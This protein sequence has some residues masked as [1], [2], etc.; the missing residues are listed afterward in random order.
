VLIHGRGLAAATSV[1]FGGIPATSFTASDTWISADAP[2][3]AAGA[4]D[5][6]VTTPNGSSATGTAAS[7]GYGRPRVFGGPWA[8]NTAGQRIYLGGEGFTGATS[9]TFDGVPGTSLTVQDDQS[10]TVDAPAHAAGWVSV[11]VSGPNGTSAN[12]YTVPYVPIA[13]IGASPVAGPPGGGTTVSIFGVGFTG[14]TSVTFGGVPGTGLVVGDDSQLIVVTP[15]HAIGTVP[16]IVTS[17]A[18]NAGAPPY[19]YVSGPTVTSI[20]PA[21]GPTTGGTAVTI[22]GTGFTGATGVTFGGGAGTG[23]TVIS[24]TQVQ[25][26]A[27]AHAAGAVDVIVTTTGGASATGPAAQFTYTQAAPVV[28][29][30]WPRGGPLAGGTTVTVYGW[31]FSSATGVTFGGV[32]ATGMV[33]VDD[34]TLTVVSPLH[35]VGT[36]DVVVTTSAG[37]NSAVS[38]AS[39]FSYGIPWVTAAS[40]SQGPWLGGTSVSL[41]GGGFTG[42]S[43]VAFDGVLSGFSVVNDNQI[44]A[45]TPFHQTGTTVVTVTGP[46]GVSGQAAEY[47]FTG[48]A[49]VQPPFQQVTIGVPATF[50]FTLGAGTTCQSDIDPAATDADVDCTV[51]DVDI[52][53]TAVVQAFAVT[54]APLAAGGTVVT[55]T[56][57]SNTHGSGSLA[58]RGPLQVPGINTVDFWQ[59][60]MWAAI[61][62][63]L[64]HVASEPAGQ[65]VTGGGAAGQ[66]GIANNG[67]AVVTR[68]R[69]SRHTACTVA[70]GTGIQGNA[71]FVPA[72][73]P[74]TNVGQVVLTTGG[75]YDGPQPVGPQA[76]TFSDAQIFIGD[77]SNGLLGA[78]CISW[79][80]M[81]AGQQSMSV[82]YTGY[83]SATHSV[84]WDSD[85]DGNGLGLPSQ[86]LVTEWSVLE[87]VRMPTTSSPADPVNG[88]SPTVALPLVLNPG[89]GLYELNLPGA[90]RAFD[91]VAIGSHLNAASARF[92]SWLAGSGWTVA[93]GPGSCGELWGP[94]TSGT[95]SLTPQGIAGNPLHAVFKAGAALGNN[96]T[97][98]STAAIVLDASHR[99]VHRFGTCPCHANRAAGVGPRGRFRD[100]ASRHRCDAVR[101]PLQHRGYRRGRREH[102][103]GRLAGNAWAGDRRSGT[104]EHRGCGRDARH[105]PR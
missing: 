43:A 71:G 102:A 44:D 78:T 9:V 94:T 67:S 62:P 20:S 39:Q 41:F 74:L 27:P 15:A 61:A 21:S 104:V 81:G 69:R 83:D 37:G 4:V 105:R 89:T 57:A 54:H 93:L 58:L 98:S 33:I 19:T 88:P 6:V 99:G 10:L 51:A 29:G 32:P 1:T 80:S 24:D 16:V 95:T 59:T 31:G 92:D 96:C 14:A 103:G 90:Q 50:T 77:G 75:G 13:S 65:P 38:A 40:P 63:E 30:M 8:I 35:G 42:A 53:P 12:P 86:P 52:S 23:L 56:V 5:V 28:T 91:A 34:G 100:R 55:V 68:A 87:K 101:G 97:P 84:L 3:H 85:G 25:V 22:T 64:R 45:V 72:L 60:F 48:I 70:P 76:P 66:A 11:A 7:Y 2:P 82:T 26:T 17:P 79:V 36:V 73:I 18:G 49:S 46:A 47:R